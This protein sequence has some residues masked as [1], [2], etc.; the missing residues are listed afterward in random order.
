MVNINDIIAIGGI[1]VGVIGAIFG[2]VPYLKNK[3]INTEEIL[4][5]TG[6]VLQAA[7]PLIQAAKA[8]PALKSAATLVDWIEKKAAA[9]VKAAE[10][11]YHAGSLTNNEEKFKAAQQ[12]VYDALK[13]IGIAPT[14][15]QKKLIDD[16]IQEAVNDL[17]H[18]T[19]A[20]AEKNAQV[21]KIQQELAAAQAEN[22]QLKQAIYSIQGYAGKTVQ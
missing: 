21:A 19:P 11:L 16:F 15:N 5:T 7:E 2:L 9:G 12:T 17:G 14:D 18:S 4:N 1:L 22:T 6:D 20:E 8:I 13:E 10:Q 3:K